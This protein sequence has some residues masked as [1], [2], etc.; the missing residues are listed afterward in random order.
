MEKISKAVC[1][2]H[3]GKKRKN[4]ED[5]FY[6]NGSFLEPVHVESDGI[7]E[8]EQDRQTEQMY[9]VFD[10]MGGG[11]YGE[12]AS[13]GA[14]QAMDVAL[15]TGFID[16][17]IESS[18]RKLSLHLNRKVYEVEK[19]LGS[20]YMGTTM[21]SLYYDTQNAWIFNV[22]DS[23]CY[24]LR[25]GSLKQLSLDHS[26]TSFV[27]W[28]GIKYAKAFLTQVLGMNPK[29][30]SIDPYIVKD[31]IQSGDIYLLCS[32]GLTDMVSNE[33]IQSILS[34]SAS[35]KEGCEQLLKM[36]LDHGGVDNITILIWQ[37]I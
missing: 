1:V 24:R 5:N 34:E 15:H 32:D 3:I 33:E 35:I 17:D 18:L 2:C 12:L 9:A 27:E 22:G 7:L 4:N 28:M 37:N 36:A 14:A 16:P 6:F 19:E 26:E 10:G 11:D 20:H 21:V 31:Q 8:I 25:E 23:R 29:E 30:Y 13:Y